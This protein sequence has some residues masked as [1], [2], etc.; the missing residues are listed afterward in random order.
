MCR[1]ATLAEQKNEQK[2]ETATAGLSVQ[3][4][5]LT[6]GVGPKRVPVLRNL[7]GGASAGALTAVLG[8]SG[9]GKSTL[10]GTVSARFPSQLRILRGSVR[11]QQNPIQAN[12]KGCVFQEIYLTRLC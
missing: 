11:S 7:T 6:V 9:S 12:L 4:Q 5:D 1:P 2:H 3:W 10:L 8:P